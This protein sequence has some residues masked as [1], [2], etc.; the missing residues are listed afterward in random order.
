MN[1]IG[2]TWNI[3]G[4]R[5]LSENWSG[6][7]TRIRILHKRPHQGCASVDGGLTKTQVT[8][9]PET[10]WPVMC[11]S[12]S[13]C[14]QKKAKQQCNIEKPKTQVSSS[15]FFLTKLKTL[16]PLF[17]TPE[18]LE[19]QWNQQCHAL[20]EYAPPPP[21]YRRRELQC[22][23]WAEGHPSI[24]RLSLQTEEKGE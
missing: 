10:I 21:T 6:G 15:I 12:M 23:R 2:D 20:H 17:R 3:N 7:S 11:S 8:S 1:R 4:D 18:I 16:T 9:R 22:Q 5:N 24:E 14:A 19:F 13:R